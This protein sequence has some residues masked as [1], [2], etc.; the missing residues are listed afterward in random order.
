M[1]DNKGLCVIK[2]NGKKQAFSDDKLRLS[3]KRSGAQKEVIEQVLNKIH[4]E[5][6]D[7]VTTRKIYRRAYQMLKKDTRIVA[8]RYNL[9]K[10]VM[11]MGPSGFPFELFVGEIF[12]QKGYIV[13]T[14]IFLQGWCVKYE[15]DVSARKDGVHHVIECKYHNKYGVKSDLK[16]AL[17]V[18]ARA[19]DIEKRHEHDR[20]DGS[21]DHEAWLVTN[22]KL[23]SEA[24][25]YS[26]CAGVNVIG[27]NYPRKGNLHDLIIETKVHPITALSTIS[28]SQKK[29]LMK[30]G[31]VLCRQVHYKPEVINALGLT[32]HKLQAFMKEVGDVCNPN[33]SHK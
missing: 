26:G 3:L 8:L 17:Y 30:E 6:S 21:R 12:K 2:A 15:I 29:Q 9:R 18:H 22:T 19:M 24:A 1:D 27:W 10:A 32:K 28:A 25:K 7:C 4:S 16:T 13:K 11:D 23:T 31:V 20:A 14:N 5:F 33:D